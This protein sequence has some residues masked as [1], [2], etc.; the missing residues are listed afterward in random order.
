MACE[1]KIRMAICSQNYLYCEGLKKLL[2]DEHS[3]EVIHIFSEKEDLKEVIKMNPDI[4]LSTFNSHFNILSDLPE[5][6]LS[7]NQI[8]ILFIGDSTLPFLADEHLKELVSRGV[9]GILPPSAD[10][11]LLKKALMAVQAGEIWLDRNT[12]MKILRSMRDQER[13]KGLAKR[14]REVVS[15]ICRGYRNKEIAL[16]LNISEQTVKSHCYRIYRKLG[17][18]DRLQLAIY[19]LKFG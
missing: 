3:I 15:Y 14:E 16:V 17:V 2:E 9:V 19:C 8:K 1:M 11:D 13:N 4:I 10:S 7:G 18:S 12:L 6:F 5:D